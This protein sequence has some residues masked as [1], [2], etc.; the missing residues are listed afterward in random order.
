MCSPWEDKRLKSYKGVCGFQT[1]LTPPHKQCTHS[2][3]SLQISGH[4]GQ[5]GHRFLLISGL[6]YKEIIHHLCENKHVIKNKHCS[7]RRRSGYIIGLIAP[8]IGPNKS[9]K[10]TWIIAPVHN[11]RSQVWMKNNIY[12]WFHR[13]TVIICEA[14]YV[15][16]I[17]T[18]P[19]MLCAGAISHV[20]FLDM[21]GPIA[22]Q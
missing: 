4:N 1:K 20:S 19:C 8:A 18:M 6:F 15:V 13:Q 14:M 17:Q 22:G 7:I 16:F 11:I 12:T 21:F 10:F 5:I 9:K 2:I 3:V